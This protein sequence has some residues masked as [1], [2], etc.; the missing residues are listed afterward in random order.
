MRYCWKPSECTSQ[1][2]VALA[3]FPSIGINTKVYREIDG[4]NCE[5]RQYRIYCCYGL[6]GLV[7]AQNLMIPSQ[8]PEFYQLSCSSHN[9]H[10]AIG[11]FEHSSIG[12]LHSLAVLCSQ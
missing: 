9:F 2:N 1:V 6:S 8:T 3:C 11:I 10:N 7:G 5:V 4:V 12:Q